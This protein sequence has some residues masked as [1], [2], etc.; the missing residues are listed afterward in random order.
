MGSKIFRLLFKKEIID[1]KSGFF[2]CT[3]FSLKFGKTWK[4]I[5]NEGCRSKN[6]T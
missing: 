4:R 1:G 6:C 2:L 5:K 3:E